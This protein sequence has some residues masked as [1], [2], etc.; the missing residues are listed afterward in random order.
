[1]K[2]PFLSLSPFS[3]WFEAEEEEEEEEEDLLFFS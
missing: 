3:R 1:M 2:C